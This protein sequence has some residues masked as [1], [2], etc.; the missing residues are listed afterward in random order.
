MTEAWSEDFRMAPPRSD[1]FEGSGMGS[2]LT[3][4]SSPS[5]HTSLLKTYH[6]SPPHPHP[7][8]YFVSE[9]KMFKI[10]TVVVQMCLKKVKIIKK[11][12]NQ[13]RLQKKSVKLWSLT[14]WRGEGGSVRVVKKPNSFFEEEN[15]YFFRSYWVNKFPVKKTKLGDGGGG[16]EWGLVKDWT[17]MEYFFQQPSLRNCSNN[18]W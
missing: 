5:L 7:N 14:K 15:K 6:P 13:G 2:S 17:C 10:I 9:T 8:H 3:P 1:S 12:A 16:S 11:K 4:V 18:S